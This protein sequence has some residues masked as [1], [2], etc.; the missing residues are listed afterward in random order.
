[1]ASAADGLSDVRPGMLWKMAR[2]GAI[3]MR[4]MCFK[5]QN[6]PAGAIIDF[7]AKTKPELKDVKISVTRERQ[8]DR[9][10]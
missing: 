10:A 5:G 3:S 2:H 4:M 7:W 1:M 8:A 6:P 9:D